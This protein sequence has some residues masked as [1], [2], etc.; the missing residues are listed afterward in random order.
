MEERRK[1]ISD[2]STQ[3]IL[4]DIAKARAS[5]STYIEFVGG[6]PTIRKDFLKL[7]KYAKEQGFETIMFAT[8]GR[9]LSNKEYA[10]K[11][12]EAGANHIVFSIH[13]HNS[14]LHDN[15]TKSSGS[16]KQLMKGIDN[17]KT[18]NFTNIGSNTAIVKQNYL[19]LL[20][21]AKLI[22]KLNI[23]ISEFIFV[24]PTHGAPKTDFENIVPKYEQVS[25]KVNELLA[26]AKENKMKHWHVRYYP[27]CF[28]DQQ[29]H[30][31]VSEIHEVNTFNT[32]HIAPDFSNK[33]VES[34]RRSISR[35][36]KQE[37][38]VC[39]YNSI[40]EGYW[41]EYQNYSGADFYRTDI[42]H[43]MLTS[44]CNLNCDYCY[45]KKKDQDMS[46][47]TIRKSID[48][49][50]N[51]A[52]KDTK[53]ALFGGEPLLKK[54]LFK[55]AI[56]YTQKKNKTLSHKVGFICSTNGIL[57][58]DEFIKLFKSNSIPISVS[59][60]GDMKS[61]LKNRGPASET[62]FSKIL[63]NIRL[64]QKSSCKYD[65][66]MTV[67]PNCV[68]SMLNNVKFLY[69][70]GCKEIRLRAAS[71]VSW[72]M[73]EVKIYLNQLKKIADLYLKL[74]KENNDFKFQLFEYYFNT[75][76]VTPCSKGRNITVLPD[77]RILP[78]YGYLLNPENVDKH[79]IGHILKGI[80]FSKRRKYINSTEKH[81][82]KACKSLF[83]CDLDSCYRYCL[84][85]DDKTHNISQ[86][87]NILYREIKERE[88]SQQLFNKLKQQKK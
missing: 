88:I 5:G 2:K 81:L 6:E 84:F 39:I 38:S 40:C 62:L 65:I 1:N 83:N 8:N 37:C 33:D 23:K 15:L 82:E 57:I 59:I 67:A 52:N 48:M 70:L 46:K 43:L 79:V 87:K 14:S 75:D 31:A 25:A 29:F 11:I 19:H 71:C 10:Q 55:Y 21:I 20:D 22:D 3:E 18:L 49:I 85:T 50:F 45:V 68:S 74:H 80:D 60:D 73:D 64:L 34:S 63:Q 24:D 44:K 61:Q 26:Y 56:A 54:D 30:D 16:F 69:G 53:I 51:L 32:E 86:I 58:N 17:L 72:S 28:I 13:G 4:S 36:K 77:G 41:K 78:C 47:E 76:K 66:T 7:V 35:M 12:L 42:V 27:L 9:M